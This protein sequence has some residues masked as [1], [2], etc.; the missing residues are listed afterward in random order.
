MASHTS[1]LPSPTPVQV[2]KAIAGAVPSELSQSPLVGILGVVLGAGIVT[3]TGRMLTLGTAD[4][5]GSL[6]IGFDDGAWIASAFNIALM[7]IGPFTVYL[8]G[9]LGAR[10]VLMIAAS[11]F[12]L[13]CALLPLVH[14]YSLLITALV[15]AGLT[16]G[17]FYPLTLSF[18]LKNIPLRFLPFTL[19]LYATF[20]DGAVNIAPSL[21]GWYRDHLS[22]HWMFWNSAVLTPVMLVCI[23]CGI[24][25]APPGKKP[26][27]APSFAGFLY[28]S[29]GFTML[30]AALDQGQRLGWG[31][32]GVFKG[33]FGGAIVFLLASLIRRL[34]SPNPLVDLPYLR[35]WNTTV[36][37]FCLGLFRFCL[38]GTIILVPQALAVH[39]FEADQIGPAVLWTAA[40][41]IAIAIIA[42]LLL[43]HGLDS[44]LLLGVGF[45]GLGARWF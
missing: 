35:Q 20:V 25:A 42:A 10:R 6:G 1:A 13:L 30:F 11:L 29:A 40:P 18:A 3:L 17:T 33:I 31:R 9:L 16:S 5:K 24:P 23:Y 36:L 37:S 45:P 4:L 22:F 14:S 39:G 7:F 21:Y 32:A 38:L 26:G 19:A 34:R 41:Q 8:G 12:T 2:A 15:L 44:R 27:T 28:A 43:L